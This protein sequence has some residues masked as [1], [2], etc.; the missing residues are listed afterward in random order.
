M[1]PSVNLRKLEPIALPERPD[2]DLPADIN[3]PSLP[4]FAP[5]PAPHL[6]IMRPSKSLRLKATL[7][8]DGPEIPSDLVWRLFAPIPGPDGKLPMV[9]VAK[10]PQADF[11]IP[12]GNYLLHVGFGRAGMTKRIYFSGEQTQETVALDAGGLRLHAGIGDG[13]VIPPDRVRVDV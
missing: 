13:A 4:A 1:A 10:G 11:D 12:S 2:L 5:Q 8:K 7:G 3:L 6:D 9:A